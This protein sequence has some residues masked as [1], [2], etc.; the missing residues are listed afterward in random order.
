MLAA[1]AATTR[2]RACGSPLVARLREE[3]AP[4]AQVMQTT[5]R[6]GSSSCRNGRVGDRAAC[7]GERQ[8]N[9]TGR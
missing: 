7:C 2:R 4:Y 8:P 6:Y 9:P 5:I 1:L 3:A